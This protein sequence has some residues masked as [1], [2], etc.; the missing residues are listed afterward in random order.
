MRCLDRCGRAQ[1]PRVAQEIGQSGNSGERATDA[2]GWSLSMA[3]TPSNLGFDR[4]QMGAVNP[5]ERV[6]PGAKGHL[7][8][9][10]RNHPNNRL[11]QLLPWNFMPPLTAAT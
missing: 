3:N 4:Q 1:H 11:D 10:A 6:G 7:C 8:V 5:L 2:A 9:T